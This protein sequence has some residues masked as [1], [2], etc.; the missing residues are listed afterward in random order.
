MTK[1]WFSIAETILPAKSKRCFNLTERKCKNYCCT[2]INMIIIKSANI[3]TV[4]MF[5]NEI[6]ESS[7]ISQRLILSLKS[8]MA[9]NTKILTT[10]IHSGQFNYL[11]YLVNQANKSSWASSAHLTASSS[12]TLYLTVHPW[13]TFGKIFTNPSTY[14]S[15]K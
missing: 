6:L 15:K 14:K 11:T 3:M 10:G 5:F 2:I 1:I 13:E 9:H 8:K 12:S 4:P 7:S